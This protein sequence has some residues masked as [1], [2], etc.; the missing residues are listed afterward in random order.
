MV[1]RLRDSQHEL[2]RKI[3]ERTA[4]LEAAPSAMLMVDKSGKITLANKLTE[5][6]FGYTRDELLGQ[7]IEILIPERFRSAHPGQRESFFKHP[8]TRAMGAGRDLY[9]LRRDGSEVPI[10]IGLNPLTT[11]EGAFVLA[12]IIDITERKR[13]EERFR[14]VVE[15]SPS[16]MLMVNSEGRITLVNN[17]TE[18]LFGYDRSEL[19]GQPM[20]I[21]V[22]ERYRGGHP[23]HRTNFF[24]HPSTRS[25]GAG[26]DLYG[27][28]KDGT[29]MPIE[30]GLNPITTDEGAFVLANII[31]ITERKQAEQKFQRV[32]ESSPNAIVLVGAEGKIVLVN[33]RTE[34]LF[35][36]SREELIGEPLEVLV[37]TRFRDK[38]PTHRSAFYSSPSTRA[39]G[40]GRDLFGLHK[41][42]REVPI[43]I[44]L[45]PIEAEE[46]TLVLATIIDI[47]E[48]KH[49]EEE[50]HRLNDELE[51]RVIERTTQLEAANKE[52][53]AFSY[54]ASHDLRAPL[55]HLAG[56]AS[57]LQKNGW[58]QLDENSRRYVNTI[59]DEAN[60][61][62]DLIDH[63]LN[64][65]RLGRAELQK[66]TVDLEKLVAE[67]V[68]KTAVP[69]GQQINWKISALPKVPGDP[70]L[71]RLVFDNLLSNA[72][73]FTR[74]RE[75][76]QVEIGCKSTDPH[77]VL[78]VKDNGEGFDMRYVNKLFGVFQRLHRADEFEGTG[79]GLANVRRIIA[80]HGG[81]TWAE[82]DVGKGATFFLSLPI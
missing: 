74:K 58:K 6:L 70:A 34:R 42:G 67:V 26:R 32:V 19:L 36:Y 3:E 27:R 9:G 38:H 2:E 59:I 64:F 63:L 15:A 21:L 56:Y 40:A 72:V 61:M 60:R 12:S 53:E 29:E 47:T 11:S 52:M 55:R 14:L 65:S 13:A 81:T 1:T 50:I 62:G 31:D 49:A 39:M 54:S 68:A 46:G 37:P 80:R 79:I 35:G 10:E 78:F 43:E 77:A 75:Q 44:G 24:Q 48:R 8:S 69:D 33:A 23:G 30:I 7:H 41:D 17:Q 4:Q 20:E 22:P 71:L 18:T 76:P 16:A 51:V 57:L 5:Q 25:M 28:R 82:G 73:K 45:N 66:R